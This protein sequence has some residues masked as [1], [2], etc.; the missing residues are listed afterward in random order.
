MR[1]LLAL[2]IKYY[3]TILFLILEAAAIFL[4]VQHNSYQRSVF[5]GAVENITG[6]VQQRFYNVREYFDLKRTN[7][8]LLNE[9]E[10]LHN[11][12]SEC[13]SRVEGIHTHI[14]TMD[15]QYVYMQADVINNST[16][17]QFNYLT[18]NRGSAHGVKEEMAVISSTGVVGI[19]VDVA[20]NFSTV[21]PV[22]NRRFKLSAKFR[23]NDF[24]GSLHWPGENYRRVALKEIPYHVNVQLGDQVV[25]SGYS[26][27][28]PENIPIG[29]VVEFD[30]EE[31]NFY[32]I[33]VSL[34]TDFKKLNHV[35]IIK[36]ML[37]QEQV[38]MQEP[39]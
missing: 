13:Q 14:D 27:I 8:V 10:Y 31:G 22:L 5:L 20:T 33:N 29:H 28:F 11:A 17:K 35:Y 18:V 23:K 4:V 26:A 19:V 39:E 32:D 25:T 30:L 3:H 12:L 34:S 9:N 37:R 1:N 2:I 6:T 7:R 16:N 15:G 24:F 38:Q 36:N 21:L